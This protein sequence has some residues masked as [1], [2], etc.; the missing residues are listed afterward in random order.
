MKRVLFN[1]S[2][3]L[4][5]LIGLNPLVYF[6]SDQQVGVLANKP[7]ELRS[8]LFYNLGFYVHIASSGT[9]L[10]VGWLQFSLKLRTMKAKLHRVVGKVYILASLLGSLSGIYLGFYAMGGLIAAVGFIT[11]G[12]IWFYTTLGGFL[13][14]AKKK[15]LLHQQMMMYSYACCLA[16]VTLRLYLPILIWCFN[17]FE[18]AYSIVAWLCWVPNLVV[19]FLISKGIVSTKSKQLVAPLP[20]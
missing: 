18:L 6:L 17:D 2:I 1:F 11:L 9:G 16:G 5:I 13:K 10:L 15:I 4:I 3:L 20:N 12:I 19:A 7:E 8:T 14:I